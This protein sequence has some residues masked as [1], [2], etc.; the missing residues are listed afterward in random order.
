MRRSMLLV[1]LVATFISTSSFA[2]NVSREIEPN[3]IKGQAT[4]IS[5]NNGQIRGQLS[6]AVDVDYYQFDSAGG[7]VRF[8]IG[9]DA[10][11]A[12]GAPSSGLMARIYAL[13]DTLITSRAITGCASGTM[14]IVDANTASGKYYLQ[15][16]APGS[17][18]TTDDYVITPLTRLTPASTTVR[19]V[20]PNNNASS[21]T[22]ILVN[23]GEVRGQLSGDFDIDY[24][25]F[26]SPGGI[27]TFTVGLDLDCAQNFVIP[28]AS[29]R[30]SIRAANGTLITSRDL[31]ACTS[32][33]TRAAITTL[34]ANTVAGTYYLLIQPKVGTTPTKSDYV[35]YPSGLFDEAVLC[36]MDL[37]GNGSV[38]ALTDGLMMMRAFFGL[39]GAAVTQNA[40][41]AGA[42]RTQWS[43]IRLYLNSN[44]G[45]NFG[46]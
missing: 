23:G 45:T 22:A 19:E 7:V 3:D 18:V 46:P 41:G 21:A 20:E 36:S 16:S 35:I 34:A 37:D 30:V 40:L 42:T 9:V 25:G 44:C 14:T 28:E 11:C 12:G 5:L 27:V 10:D 32:G 29:I 26:V 8:L 13:D 1:A 33:T 6:T 43:D 15:I 24:F 31:L 39:T 2:A 17:A 4:S 38:E